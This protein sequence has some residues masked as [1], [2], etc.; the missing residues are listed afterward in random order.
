MT[1]EPTTPS[2]IADEQ[3]VYTVREVAKKLKVSEWMVHKL[4]RERRLRSVQIGVRRLVAAVDLEE[5]LRELRRDG[6]GVRYGR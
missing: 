3:L 1:P 4:I 2:V 6:R 5:Y